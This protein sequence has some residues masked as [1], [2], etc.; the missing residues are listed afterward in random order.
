MAVFL[1][2]L[3]NVFNEQLNRYLVRY[4]IGSNLTG[5]PESVI[6]KSNK[7]TTTNKL[8]AGYII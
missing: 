8:E 6:S 5:Q 2:V 4:R 1:V 7:L 3:L